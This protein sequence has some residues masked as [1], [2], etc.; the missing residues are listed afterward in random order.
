MPR[1]PY[2]SV[3]GSLMYDMMCLPL[4]LDYVVSA[5]SR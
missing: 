1:V 2:S 4:D 3:M 5:V